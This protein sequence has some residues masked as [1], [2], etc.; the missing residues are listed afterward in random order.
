MNGIEKQAA[1]YRGYLTDERSLVP[2]TIALATVIALWLLVYLVAA[3]A[4]THQG[5]G[6]GRAAFVSFIRDRPAASSPIGRDASARKQVVSTIAWAISWRGGAR[7][8]SRLQPAPGEL[9][10]NGY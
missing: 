10:D 1:F 8:S 2:L 4:E 9:C 3:V 6:A 7:N 5:A